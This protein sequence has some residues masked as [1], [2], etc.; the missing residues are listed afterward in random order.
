MPSA[1]A[2]IR[3]TTRS[4]LVGCSTGISAGFA[5]N[6]EQRIRAA[7]PVIIAVFVK[8]QT[9]KIFRQ[10]LHERYGGVHRG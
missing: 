9:A 4:N 10:R 5:P 8:P 6:L 7:H 2:V 1:W 3:F